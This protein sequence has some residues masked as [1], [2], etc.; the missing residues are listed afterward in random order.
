MDFEH[1]KKIKLIFDYFKDYDKSI[2]DLDK[3][4]GFCSQEYYDFFTKYVDNYKELH[5][6]CITKYQQNKYF[7]NEFRK[8]GGTKY[9]NELEYSPGVGPGTKVQQLSVIEPEEH[10]RTQA[11]LGYNVDDLTPGKTITSDDKTTSITSKS[12][13]SVVSVAG[14]L[15]PSY[16]AYKVIITQ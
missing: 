14:I 2:Q 12:I 15:V 1:F 6:E 13:N 7:C 11:S 3:H 4:K 10:L 5:E 9:P 16:L 8:H